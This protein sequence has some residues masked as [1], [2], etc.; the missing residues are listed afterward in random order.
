M[1]ATDT[2][3]G[4]DAMNLQLWLQFAALCGA[5]VCSG[6]II[7]LLP[8]RAAQRTMEGQ[9]RSLEPFF[10]DRQWREH[11][12]NDPRGPAVRDLHT[13]NRKRGC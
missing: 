11:W 5:V 8:F 2:P 6:A 10:D 12:R 7:A 4:V 13:Y 1:E 3:E 9:L